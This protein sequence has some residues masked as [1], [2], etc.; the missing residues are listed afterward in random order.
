MSDTHIVPHVFVSTCLEGVFNRFVKSHNCCVGR[1]L[2]QLVE[3]AFHVQ[4]LCPHCGGPG[5]ECDPS[6]GLF[7]QKS[8]NKAKIKKKIKNV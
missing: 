2:A 8:H 1:P 5:F 4:R 7:Y 3:P 6:W